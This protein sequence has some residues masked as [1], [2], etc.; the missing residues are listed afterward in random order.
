MESL[1]ENLKDRTLYI[2]VNKKFLDIIEDILRKMGKVL[3]VNI[4]DIVVLDYHGCHKCSKEEFDNIR[5][6]D[7]IDQSIDIENK[8]I[9][10]KNRP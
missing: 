4:G 9:L 1:K 6:E 8:Y 2:K 10:V 5:L 3:T 7:I